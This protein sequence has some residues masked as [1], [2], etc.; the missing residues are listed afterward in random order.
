[1]RKLCKI[2]TIGIGL[3]L[4]LFVSS[5]A[6]DRSLDASKIKECHSPVKKLSIAPA[7]RTDLG[8]DIC[9]VIHTGPPMF[10]ITDWF[11]E[12]DSYA[13]FQ[14]PLA[15]GCIDPYPFQVME[16]HFWV[17]ASA[18]VTTEIFVDILEANLDDPTCP[19]PGQGKFT[20]DIYI[21]ELPA[22]GNYEIMV[23]VMEKV[24]VDGPY[25]AGFNFMGPVIGLGPITDDIP[26]GC[27]DYIWFDTEPVDL[28]SEMGFPGNI[29]LYSIGLTAEE[30]TC[31]EYPL[32]EPEII[33]P[34]DTAWYDQTYF[35]DSV[36]IQ[37]EDLSDGSKIDYA[38]F[39]YMDPTGIWHPIGTDYDGT[40]IW[41]DS[42]DTT[43][44]WADGWSYVWE[45]NGLDEDYYLIRATM[46]DSLGREASDTVTIYYD[47]SPPIPTI[48]QPESTGLYCSPI[49]VIF[50]LEADHIA[51][52]EGTIY[53]FSEGWYTAL[54]DAA[55]STYNKGIPSMK[56]GDHYPDG[57]N[58]KGQRVNMGCAPT[59]GAAC[60]K[61]WAG[62]SPSY[63]PLVQGLTDKQLVNGLAGKGY[64]RT[65]PGSGT[66][67]ARLKYGLNRWVLDKMG[68]CWFKQVKREKPKNWKKFFDL[69]A[70]ELKKEDI[71]I[72]WSGKPWHVT[73][74]NSVTAKSMTYDV[75]NP[76]TGNT[77]TY[78][79]PYGANKSY[80]FRMWIL[81]PKVQ[82]Q[83]PPATPTPP[84]TQYEQLENH[85]RILWTPDTTETPY[86]MWYAFHVKVT[87]SL[88]HV[89]EDK[90]FFELADYVC[91]DANGDGMVSAGDVVY[92]ISYLFR[93]G[94]LPEPMESGDANCDG[95]VGAGDVVYLLSYLFREGPL[96]GCF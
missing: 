52:M 68:P 91:G 34:N 13:S 37:V 57:K 3:F 9:E 69:Y 76:T 81:S 51:E 4:A 54:K 27:R 65:R 16:I 28:V 8:K 26:Y 96:P 87:D 90:F 86:N 73:T 62:Q 67:E 50:S 74:G 17:C 84:P 1:M 94:P 93:E 12:G 70:S 31:G 40:D 24:C 80:I 45:A 53:N 5:W 41:L 88:G 21:I 78:K 89:G 56:Q 61:W 20:S 58:R 92:N 48:V 46:T 36:R 55:D 44:V 59:A 85:Y 42:W 72:G 7:E 32:P 25:F 19:Y 79:W 38:T 43:Q 66:K 29:L 15:A 33:I 14:D 60:L 22:P 83:P 77:E 75:M 11:E 39:D 6:A 35:S 49:E 82:P 95:T 64:M 18:P 30:N 2:L 71:L 63:Q 47:P 23:P 10:C